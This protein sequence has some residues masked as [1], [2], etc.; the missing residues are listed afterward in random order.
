MKTTEKMSMNSYVQRSLLVSREATEYKKHWLGEE[1]GHS[2][3]PRS[4]M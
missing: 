1:T 2:W 3:P 4:E